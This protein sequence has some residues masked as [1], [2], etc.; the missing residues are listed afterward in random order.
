MTTLLLK[1]PE[2]PARVHSTTMTIA[3]KSKD[4]FR[5]SPAKLAL[6]DRLRT[7]KRKPAGA[8]QS[9]TKTCSFR[10]ATGRW[11][12]NSWTC[13]LLKGSRLQKLP[14]KTSATPTKKESLNLCASSSARGRPRWY[15]KKEK[16]PFRRLAPATTTNSISTQ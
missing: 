16:V 6:T 3:T 13:R 12:E 8:N 2:T 1:C 4:Q 15:K 7:P 10:V 11:P 9:T 14:L 5:L